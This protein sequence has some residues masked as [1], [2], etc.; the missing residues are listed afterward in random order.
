MTAFIQIASSFT[1]T[2]IEPSLRRSLESACFPHPLR[3]A[4]YARMSQS[5]LAPDAEA[6]GTVVLLRLEDWLRDTL[7][8]EPAGMLPQALREFLKARTDEFVQ[9]ISAL[10]Q[11][12]KPVWLL[13]CPSTGWV[14]A[15][16]KLESLCQ[17]YTNLLGARIRSL[18][19]VT[20]LQWPASLFQDEIQDRS[21]DRL[22]QI[23]FTQEAFDKLGEFLGQQ[24]AKVSAHKTQG[25]STTTKDGAAQLSAYLSSLQVQV[26]LVPARATDRSHIDHLLRNAASFTL[27]GEQRDLSEE[28]IDAY[29]NSEHCLLATVSDR[30]ADYGVTALVA[31]RMDQLENALAIHAMAVSCAVLGKQA[32]FA[33]VSALAQIAREHGLTKLVFEYRRSDRNQ[34]MLAFLQAIADSG[35]GSTYVLPVTSAETRLQAAASS[36]GAWTVRCDATVPEKKISESVH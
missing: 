26:S 9:Q 4:M 22:G 18:S 14:A 6:S 12:G 23:A 28:D 21:A 20:T 24:I 5:L 25:A 3:F 29:L 16:H 11:F 7:K 15:K 10:S 2:P 33:L 27:T 19:Q 35:A 30:I 32:E 13:V 31:F 1:S 17:T 36:A 8:S 34:P